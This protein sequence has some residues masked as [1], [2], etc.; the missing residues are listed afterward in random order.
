[1]L[2]L[3][4]ARACIAWAAVRTVRHS[5]AAG[6][7]EGGH[8]DER[9]TRTPRSLHPAISA[10]VYAHVRPEVRTAVMAAQAEGLGF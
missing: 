7:L 5:I 6:S 3:C 8:G 4:A 1:M 9:R 2:Q 10:H